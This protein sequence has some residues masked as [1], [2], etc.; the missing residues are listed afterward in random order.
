MHCSTP[1]SS[2]HLAIEN[3]QASSFIIIFRSCIRS[4]PRY[5][6]Q[7]ET[8]MLFL[9]LLKQ[10]WSRDKSTVI[11]LCNAPNFRLVNSPHFEHDVRDTNPQG[12]AA[13]ACGTFTSRCG[14]NGSR[15]ML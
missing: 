3:L 14:F 12:S 15:H 7:V 13:A 9:K 6:L 4:C 2:L 11:R 10:L 1:S 5:F 8:V